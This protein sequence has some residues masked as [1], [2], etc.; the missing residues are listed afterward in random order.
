MRLL[1][2]ATSQPF[3]EKPFSTVYKR[4]C[5]SYLLRQ[6]V[7]KEQ[8]WGRRR[9]RG[10]TLPLTKG[11][12]AVF[13]L[14]PGVRGADLAASFAL[15][16][17][18]LGTRRMR[19]PLSV[20]GLQPLSV[21]YVTVILV[22]EKKKKKKGKHIVPRG[23]GCYFSCCWSGLMTWKSWQSVPNAP[24]PLLVWCDVF[25]S[26]ESIHLFPGHIPLCLSKYFK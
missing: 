24:Q 4:F 20:L 11:L 8:G 22:L 7:G 13:T 15:E 12:F 16:Q 1:A 18:N 19:K 2:R 9:S 23:K 26:W 25:S 21:F 6:V 17:H 10:R 5:V 14:C 3:S